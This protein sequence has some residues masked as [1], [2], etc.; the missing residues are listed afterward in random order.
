M[1]NNN[2]A[3]NSLAVRCAILT[4]PIVLTAR[5]LELRFP[6]PLAWGVSMVAWMLIVYWF[7]S[8]S[9]HVSL[10]K[11]LMIVGLSAT[12]AVLTAIVIPEWL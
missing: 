12:L 1:A 6:R 8:R 3:D 7:P 4:M 11:W 5:L 9:S 10:K 2:Y